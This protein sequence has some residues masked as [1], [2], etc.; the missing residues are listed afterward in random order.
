MTIN[1]PLSDQDHRDS[2]PYVCY[3]RSLFHLLK[4]SWGLRGFEWLYADRYLGFGHVDAS[5]ALRYRRD[6]LSAWVDAHSVRVQSEV[7][8]AVGATRDLLAAGW[9]VRVM[10]D[11]ARPDGGH[12]LTSTV[13]DELTDDLAIVT[14]TNAADGVTRKPVPVSEFFGRIA[15]GPDGRVELDALRPR[16]EWIDGLNEQHGLGLFRAVMADTFGYGFAEE[17]MLDGSPRRPSES[18]FDAFVDSVETQAARFATDGIPSAW[19]LRLNKHVADKVAPVTHAWRKIAA[20]PEVAAH[21]ADSGAEVL[22]AGETCDRRLEKLSEAFSFAV[23]R[24]GTATV[25]RLT[26]TVRQVADDYRRFQTAAHAAT[27]VLIG[28]SA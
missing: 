6:G 17:L 18:G 19:H 12:Y 21:L 8:T 2:L 7:G 16:Q 26:T 13:I 1:I 23:G 14:K 3:E 11:T 24:P 5:E 22:A 28:A 15:V 25:G 20:D 10:A 4:R 9:G 27:R